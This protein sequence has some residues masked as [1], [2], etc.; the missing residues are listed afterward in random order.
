MTGTVA[1]ILSK[2]IAVSAVSGVKSYSLD[3]AGNL[4][5]ELNDGTILTRPFIDVDN[6]SIDPI[7][8]HLM[9]TYSNG[10]VKD[11]GELPGGVGGECVF[12][13]DTA[14]DHTK[15]KLWVDT[16]SSG[17]PTG[18][19]VLT[20]DLLAT[21]NIGSVYNGKFYPAGTSFE[22][23]LRDILI[24]YSKPVITI[25]INPTSVVYDIVNDT[26][27]NIEIIANVTKKSEEISYVKFYVND[28]LVETMDNPDDVKIGGQFRFTHTFTPATNKTFKVKVETR[29]VTTHT[30]VSAQTTVTFIGK[31]YQGTIE[32]GTTIDA[33][34]IKAL[35]GD[36][37][38]KL[39]AKYTYSAS[40]G[41]FI[42]AYP[43]ELG[44][45][46]SVKDMVNN[47][48][49]GDSVT[50]T[51]T[52]IDGINYKVVYLTDAAGFDNVEITY[53]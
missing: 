24:S 31:C 23:A 52:V 8:N 4:I 53:A 1:Y 33:T 17:V 11:A 50:H 25:G 51:T 7:T 19:A 16:S 39:G 2:N 43:A 18:S 42:Y 26:L 9:V 15:Y 5:I 45:V 37:K 13:G 20:T 41:R 21:T 40:Y 6:V 35:T 44:T 32:D 10:V 46:T 30:V 3:G 36:L 29:D 22:V 48:N 14:P 38:N 28:V 27:S 12:V 49:Y 34:S 47:L